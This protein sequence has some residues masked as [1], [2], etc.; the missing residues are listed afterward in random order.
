MQHV[1]IILI[2]MVMAMIP[3]ESF[4]YLLTFLLTCLL[5]YVLTYLP[6]YLLICSLI[7]S[8]RLLCVMQHVCIIL[9]HVVMAMIPD[10]SARVKR[11]RQYER[12]LAR[13]MAF[14]EKFGESRRR[15][16]ELL[17]LSRLSF[18]PT[19]DVPYTVNIHDQ[20]LHV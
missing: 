2:H 8:L 3:D 16:D 11:L 19:N 9:I 1:C 14:D 18:L 20:G 5:T 10:E 13:K 15:R 6:T 17:R 12:E 7:L 4:I